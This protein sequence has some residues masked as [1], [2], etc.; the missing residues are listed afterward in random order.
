MLGEHFY[1][2]YRAFLV[3]VV[4]SEEEEQECKRKLVSRHFDVMRVF[5]GFCL[6]RKT[7]FITYVH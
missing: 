2:S 4:V 3:E 1:S 6:C 5:L 7:P